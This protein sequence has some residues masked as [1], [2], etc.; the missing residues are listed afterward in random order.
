MVWRWLL[1]FDFRVYGGYFSLN[2][3]AMRLPNYVFMNHEHH[4]HGHRADFRHL[5]ELRCAAPSHRI[6]RRARHEPT[7]TRRASHAEPRRPAMTCG[8]I[9]R[10]RRAVAS[11]VIKTRRSRQA[12][13]TRQAAL[14]YFESR[15]VEPRHDRTRRARHAEPRRRAS[16]VERNDSPSVSHVEPMRHGSCG[17][18]RHSSRCRRR[19][20]L[21]AMSATAQ[22]LGSEPAS[23]VPTARVSMGG[24]VR[25]RE[26][27]RCGLI[28]L[29]Q[30]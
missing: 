1:S 6:V 20:S 9:T 4:G 24:T 11:S 26:A 3:G 13:S 8:A 29:Q 16:C 18:S 10:T 23:R 27:W 14:R 17:A 15:H 19:H 12:N 2:K 30:G 28:P 22:R 5:R 25:C 21:P 7:A